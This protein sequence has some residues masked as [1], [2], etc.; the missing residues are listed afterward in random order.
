MHNL[1]DI[2]YAKIIEILSFIGNLSILS[3]S[4]V[5]GVNKARKY[6][7]DFNECI[8]KAFDVVDGGEQ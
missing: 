6:Q 7:E 2:K 3:V 8:D 4:S 1:E 5:V